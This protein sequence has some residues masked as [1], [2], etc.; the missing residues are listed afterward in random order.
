[1]KLTV[2]RHLCYTTNDLTGH[3]MEKTTPNY[4]LTISTQANHMPEY[5]QTFR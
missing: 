1:M 2:H 4:Y 5:G 3:L